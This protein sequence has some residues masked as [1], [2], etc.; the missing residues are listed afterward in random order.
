MHWNNT[1]TEQEL[2]LEIAQ[3]NR[4]AYSHL[5]R[6]YI[7]KLHQYIYPFVRNTGFETEEIIQEIFISIW[8]KRDRLPLIQSFQAYVYRMARNKLFDLHRRQH[9][10]Q[11]LSA[12]AD[13]P[14]TATAENELVFTEYTA[15][16]QKA[17][18]QLPLKRQQ[19][20]RM[21]TEEDL[22][23]AEIAQRMQISLPVVRKQ[24]YAARHFVLDFLKQHG[25]LLL[26]LCFCEAMHL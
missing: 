20:F 24:W 26:A 3:G 16:A 13:R 9:K 6:H 7:P 4:L 8:E 22:S 17:I 19:I 1:H 5:Y 18:A 15:L 11:E 12:T 2:L 25:G 10:T 14:V 21:H 23:L